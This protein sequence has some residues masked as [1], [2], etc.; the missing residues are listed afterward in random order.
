MNKS[1]LIITKHLMLGEFL[2]T[3]LQEQFK[4]F[5][6]FN[7]TSMNDARELLHSVSFDIVLTDVLGID[8]SIISIIKDISLLSPKTRCLLLGAESNASWIDRAL[9]AG[10]RG[11]LTKTCASDEIVK[12]VEALMQGRNHLSPDVI[13]SLSE[14]VA[15]GK[16]GFPHCS[17]SPRELE[18]FVQIAKGLSLKSISSNLKLSANTVGVHKHNISKK[19]GIKSSAKIARYC[20]EHGLLSS[21]A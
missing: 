8:D 3:F 13:Q 15:N 21:A 10:A 2:A 14:Y 20:I 17:L 1:V 18:V 9:R 11:F 12:A 7:S 16:S 4:D 6:V 5:T 19:T